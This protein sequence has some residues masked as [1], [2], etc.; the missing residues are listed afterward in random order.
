MPYAPFWRI[1]VGEASERN[2]LFPMDE[3]SMA[4]DQGPAQGDMLRRLRGQPA[5][6]SLVGL[7]AFA[8]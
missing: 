5:D 4:A 7:G 6:H 3:A 1:R 2:L 8:Y